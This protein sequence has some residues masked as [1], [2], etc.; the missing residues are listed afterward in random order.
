MGIGIIEP[1]DQ[2]VGTGTGSLNL[3]SVWNLTDIS[4]SLTLALPIGLIHA[5]GKALRVTGSDASDA[6]GLRRPFSAET[7][8]LSMGFFFVAHVIPP[9]TYNIFQFLRADAGRQF[10]ITL[11]PT[12]Q[13]G[14]VTNAGTTLGISG[15]DF[16]V[17]I[18]VPYHIA[19]TIDLS[20]GTGAT[21]NFNLYVNGN[22]TPILSVT[23]VDLTGQSTNKIGIFEL[24]GGR[25]DNILE[26][27]QHQDFTVDHMVFLM[28]EISIVPEV[29][30][31]KLAADGDSVV[32]WTPLNGGTN[33]AEIDELPSDGD[34]TYNSSN[35]LNAEDL[36]TIENL[37]EIPDYIYAVSLMTVMRKEESATRGVTSKL[38]IDAV[39]HDG[40]EKFLSLT[41]TFYWDHWKQNPETAVDWVEG[42]FPLISGYELT[43]VGA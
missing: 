10:Y 41:H 8:Q 33:T 42:D 23:N 4:N 7:E 29:E 1:F 36:F 11:L 19:W 21:S 16:L 43:T 32:A 15:G 25:S 14:L 3:R 24:W 27:Q 2:Y 5:T 39:K 37:P 13:F 40:T 22:P 34:T 20:G 9:L 12:G 30:L 17:E 28:D 18:G 26:G 35:T 6:N 38:Q 31:T